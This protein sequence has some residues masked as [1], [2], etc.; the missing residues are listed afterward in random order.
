[1]KLCNTLSVVFA[2]SIVLST[3]DLQVAHATDLT[4]RFRLQTQTVY[5][6]DSVETEFVIENANVLTADLYTSYFTIRDRWFN[7]VFEDTIKKTDL[8]P[9]SFDTLKTSRW[10]VDFTGQY[11]LSLRVD[12]AD[13]IDTSNNSTTGDVIAF[14]GRPTATWLLRDKIDEVAPD[15]SLTWGFMGWQP[16]QP[17]DTLASFDETEY[18]VGLDAP[19]WFGYVDFYKGAGYAHPGTFVLINPVDSSLTCDHVQW[20]P[21]INDSFPTAFHVDSADLVYGTPRPAENIGNPTSLTDSAASVA[22]NSVYAVLVSGAI[23]K[24]RDARFQNDLDFME[25]NLR[26]EKLGP[27]LTSVVQLPNAS[28]QEV[29]DQLDSMAGKYRKIYYYY[30][31]HGGRFRMV[32]RDSTSSDQLTYAKLFRKLS[33]TGTDSIVVTVDA[34]YSGTTISSFR[35]IDGFL[36]FEY[37]VIITASRSDTLSWSYP[38]ETGTGSIIE[39]NAFIWFYLLCYGDPQAETDGISGIS[40]VEAFY[41]MR[42]QNP[43][44][45]G[46]IRTMNETMDPRIYV[47]EKKKPDSPRTEFPSAD[48]SI[49]QDPPI[50]TTLTYRVGLQW[51][52]DKSWNLGTGIQYVSPRRYWTI[53]VDTLKTDLKF[54]L[55][56]TYRPEIDSLLGVKD[57]GVVHRED[58]TKPWTVYPNTIVDSTKRTITATGVE[59][60][61]DWALAILDPS[62][63]VDVTESAEGIPE[64]FLLFQNYPNPF[65][66]ATTIRYDIPEMSFV[67]LTVYNS[68][69][70]RIGSLV[71]ESQPAGSYAV[72]FDG[73]QFA[74]GVYYYRLSANS[75]IQTRSFILIK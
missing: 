20:W 56:F 8:A 50:D 68:L 75:F 29:C 67:S 37:A 4:A 49:E 25:A 74:S 6:E 30:S 39:P 24:P 11:K 34:C 9:F 53:D 36:D 12:F 43:L 70:Q 73:A 63:T 58:S 51:T 66:P 28:K 19:K 71:Q 42:Q 48:L 47:F 45:W 17:G 33:E 59:G 72:P 22:G 27:R 31:G 13:D 46:G 3:S 5:I 15:T 40:E 26:K 65:N 35:G 32:S 10:K 38:I 54:N 69:G 52:T 21:M 60:F 41:W 14:L 23:T 7:L 55:T 61:S 18:K 2:V 1:M 62:G 57:L 64:E 44:L 16:L